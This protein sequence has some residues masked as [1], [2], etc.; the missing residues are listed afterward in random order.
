MERGKCRKIAVGSAAKYL[1]SL[2]PTALRGRKWVRVNEATSEQTTNEVGKHLGGQ[3]REA[4]TPNGA[5]DRALMH[6][7]C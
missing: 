5:R 6:R 3:S 7:S 2:S 4:A 1:P